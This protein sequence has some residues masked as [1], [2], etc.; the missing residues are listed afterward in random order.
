MSN[1]SKSTDLTIIAHLPHY[2]NSNNEFSAYEPYVREIEIWASLFKTI[3]IYTEITHILPK[4]GIKQ[5]P[6]NCNVKPI[7]LKSGSGLKNNLIRLMQIPFASIH[8]FFI[9]LR[10]DLLHIRGPGI[11]SFIANFINKF[12]N[13]KAIVKWA[14]SFDKLPVKSKILN[15][16]RKL[17]LTPPSR[18][19]VLIYGKSNHPNHITFFP[20]LLSDK[21]LERIEINSTSRNWNEKIRLICVGRL[22][23]LK[24][25]DFVIKAL[26]RFDEKYKDYNWEIWII[27]DGEQRKYLEELVIAGSISSKVSFLGSKPFNEV[28]KYYQQAHIAIMPGML[29]GWPKVINEAWATGCIPFVINAGNA[30]Y[31]LS[32]TDN[33]GVIFEPDIEAFADELAKLL[34]KSTAELEEIIKNGKVANHKMTLDKF[35]EELILVINSLK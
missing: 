30:T 4:F 6:K 13:K 23:H 29:E 25:F 20:V 3:T 15:W 7:Y 21:E 24:N 33:A 14:T 32:F 31:P 5:L 17:L 26:S 12:L 1:I 28:L 2:K 16:E 27:G 34:N 35:K 22:Y 19:K 18:T 11:T 8:I 9:I 10:A